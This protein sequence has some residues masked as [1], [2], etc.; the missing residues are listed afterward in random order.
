VFRGLRVYTGGPI[1]SF[2][3][4]SIGF[5]VT[6]HQWERSLSKTPFLNDKSILSPTFQSIFKFEYRFEDVLE[7]GAKNMSTVCL[8]ALCLQIETGKR[9]CFTFF[10]ECV[11]VR[12]GSILHRVYPFTIRTALPAQPVQLK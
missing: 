9:G 11:F 10:E 2:H 3:W 7:R 12:F 4:V 6:S 8:T 1:D 5:P